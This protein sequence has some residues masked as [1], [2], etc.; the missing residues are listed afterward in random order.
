MKKHESLAIRSGLE[1]TREPMNG[2]HQH[3]GERMKTSRLETKVW[4]RGRQPRLR[5]LSLTLLAL[6]FGVAGL[7]W[8]DTVTIRPDGVVS[9]G[10][11]SGVTAA[12]LND[13]SDATLASINVATVSTFTVS[14][15]NSAAYAGA[16]INSVDV[17]VR[18]NASGSGAGE[19]IDFGAN[20]VSGTSVTVT[21]SAWNDY[22]KSNA[23][24]WTPATIDSMNVAVSNA[25][26][27]AGETLQVSDIWVVVNYT[28]P[29]VD[30]DLATLTVA[31]PTESATVSGTTRINLSVGVETLPAGMTNV[32]FSINGGA[33]V[34]ATSW[35]G[36]YWYYDW[37]TTAVANG[38]ATIDARGTDPDCSGTLVNAAVRNV[39]VNN[40]A[41]AN[42][43]TSCADCHAY[44]PQDGSSRNVPEGAVVGDHAKHSYTCSV[45]HVAPATQTAADFPHRDGNI[46]FQASIKSGA[47]SRGVSF[48]QSN[49]PTTGTC[50]N[51]SCHGGNPTP[52]W[53]V[54]TAACDT[55]HGLPP[56][57]NAHYEHYAAKGWA[58]GS[59]AMC[60]A[61]HP[62]NTA[63]HSD[64]SN[65][66]SVIVIA[67]LS[68]GGT[69]PAITC[70]ATTSGCHN[71]KA[72]PAW[73]TSGIAC[74]ACHTAG[75]AAA[76]D[77]TSGLH[78]VSTALR[79]DNTLQSGG[80]T[81]CHSGSSPSSLHW[82]GTVNNSTNATFTFAAGVT[83]VAATGCQATCHTDGGDWRRKW[84]GAAD[85][86]PLNTN[87]PGDA[88]CQNCHG[89][90]TNGWR[91][92]ADAD[93]TNH[94]DPYTGNTGDKMNQHGGC[95]TCHGWGAAGYNR[96]W[97]G[98]SNASY[99]GHGD[100][101]ITMN[102]PVG[103]GSGYNNASGGCAGACHTETPFVLNSN[104]GWTANF[105]DFGAGSCNSCHGYPPLESVPNAN[106]PA[107]ALQNYAGGGRAHALDKHI[108]Y[109]KPATDGWLWCTPCHT[110]TDH[111]TSATAWAANRTSKTYPKVRLSASL[112]HGGTA[113]YTMGNAD[114]IDGMGQCFNTTCHF[115]ESPKWDCSP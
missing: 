28:P 47:Y 45:C 22:T 85:A 106:Y 97:L 57:T 38:P 7:A 99:I 19:K 21:R 8:A 54:G 86:K 43:L 5:I 87:N 66:P 60:V 35:D 95:Q 49:N 4:R 89:D 11:W 114:S 113:T 32:E 51:V 44:P 91:W 6:V 78:N 27:G 80:C 26:L 67:G 61:C 58:T 17:Y 92:T 108:P 93:T 77:P 36:A 12:N 25:T 115:L 84:A 107:G 98:S 75:G 18:A 109:G 30:T 50:N 83:Y 41:L 65:A 40:G 2:N 9:A 90:F 105:G 15:Q 72:T 64:V 62:D 13:Q 82:N 103:T 73:N 59:Y 101:H 94:T 68:P 55:C 23:G 76:G 42:S 10:T 74:T 31:A 111:T 81:N 46:Q 53:G 48:S 56:D 52:Q 20:A 33:Y 29:C 102:G 24:P 112:N 104:S 100:G 3:Q 14:L 96:T 70:G 1:M 39:T 34:P 71:G 79:H 88:V 69:S 63:G 37:D 110:E 16:T